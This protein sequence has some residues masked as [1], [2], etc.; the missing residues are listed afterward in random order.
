MVCVHAVIAFDGNERVSFLSSVET[1]PK[2]R[3]FGWGRHYRRNDATA[4]PFGVN[5]IGMTDLF[6]LHLPLL[7]FSFIYVVLLYTVELH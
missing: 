1:R 4:K 5:V 7:C 3:F 6:Y 2:Y